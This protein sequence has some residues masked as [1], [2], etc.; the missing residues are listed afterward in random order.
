M[1]RS[2]VRLRNL[3][4]MRLCLADSDNYDDDYLPGRL[5]SGTVQAVADCC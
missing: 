3:G 2:A 5:E 1:F 4:S